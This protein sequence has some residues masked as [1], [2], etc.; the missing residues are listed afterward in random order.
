[1]E[2]IIKPTRNYRLP[3]LKLCVVRD[4]FLSHPVR[5]IS[6]SREAADLLGKMIGSN[7]REEMVAILL[8]TKHA[9]LGVHTISIGSLS[10]SIVHPRETFKQAI[11]SQAHA[12]IL[13]HN[14]PSGETTPSPEDIELT[15]RMRQA[16]TMLGISVIDHI[17]IGEG[18]SYFSFLDSGRL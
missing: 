16:G 6:T 7:D 12:I 3:V 4:S 8:D 11:V 2:D 18:S 17:I 13:G 5:K 15:T 9:V 14:H 10:M 1:M